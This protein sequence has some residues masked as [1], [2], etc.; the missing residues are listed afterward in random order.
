MSLGLA[1]CLFATAGALAGRAGTC[2]GVHSARAGAAGAVCC[3][4]RA[5]RQAIYGQMG[6]VVAHLHAAAQLIRDKREPGTHGGW[7][8][9]VVELRPSV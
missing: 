3:V 4:A 2:S 8:G 7:R 9:R 1:A 5:Q 6:E